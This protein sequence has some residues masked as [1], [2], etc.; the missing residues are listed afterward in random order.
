MSGCAFKFIKKRGYYF[1]DLRPEISFESFLTCAHRLRKISSQPRH[2]V[3]LLPGWQTVAFASAIPNACRKMK[4]VLHEI[5]T[6]LRRVSTFS[7]LP[8]ISR[9]DQRDDR[10]DGYAS[11]IAAIRFV[12]GDL[13]TICFAQ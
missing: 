6:F 5:A 9:G 11:E 7:R 2:R 4:Q 10:D 1:S 3:Y 8:Q 13:A 12:N